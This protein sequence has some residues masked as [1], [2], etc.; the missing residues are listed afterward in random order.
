M[1]LTISLQLK[2]LVLAKASKT[3][4]PGPWRKG[5]RTSARSEYSFCLRRF[6]SGYFSKWKICSNFFSC[7]IKPI[8]TWN[9][10]LRSNFFCLYF[11]PLILTTN[12]TKWSN[13]L[14]QFV[15]CCRLIVRVFDHFVGFLLKR[16]KWLEKSLDQKFI[17]GDGVC[18]GHTMCQQLSISQKLRLNFSI[19]VMLSH[20][21]PRF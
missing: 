13:T 20:K 15:D 17:L 11:D 7:K 5:N 16:L 14:K 12:P 9:E 21:K 19:G 8:L 6:V 18:W 3:S 2:H 10:G 4:N 1:L